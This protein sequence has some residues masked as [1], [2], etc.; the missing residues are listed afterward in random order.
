[1]RWDSEGAIF[2][3]RNSQAIEKI[4][5]EI[6]MSEEIRYLVNFIKKSDRGIVK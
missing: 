2:R 4:E 3:P 5:T 6:E 1:M